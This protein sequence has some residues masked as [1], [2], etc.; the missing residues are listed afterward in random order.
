M[1]GTDLFQAYEQTSPSNPMMNS[2][3]PPM[4][5]AS[6]NVDHSHNHN[7]N[8]E[9][10]QVQQMAKPINTNQDSY[11]TSEPSLQEQLQQLQI[12]LNNQKKQKK[13]DNIV[14]KYISKKKDVLKL[15][16]MALT[17][18]LA[19]S[20]HYLIIDLIKNYSLTNDLSSGRELFVKLAYPVSVLMIIWTIKVINIK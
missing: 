12:E 17:I 18:L 6:E 2:P 9:V 11:F 16:L 4:S 19:F 10:E 15:F 1:L 8:V 7:H 5:D 3:P 20:M 14:D 13:H